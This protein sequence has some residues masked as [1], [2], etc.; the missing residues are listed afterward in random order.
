[1]GV[2]LSWRVRQGAGEEREDQSERIHSASDWLP[3]LMKT[4]NNKQSNTDNA[5]TSWTQLFMQTLGTEVANL[6]LSALLEPNA[7]MRE[8]CNKKKTQ[9]ELCRIGCRTFPLMRPNLNQLS[10][11]NL[12]H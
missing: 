10:A 12:V 2:E 6:V 11:S 3:W 9:K 8:A 5:P 1:M 4:N 7:R